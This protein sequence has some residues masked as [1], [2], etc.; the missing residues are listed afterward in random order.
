ID[1][2]ALATIEIPSGIRSIDARSVASRDAAVPE[3]HVS[4]GSI[5]VI[6]EEAP[7]AQIPAARTANAPAVAITGSSS[8]RLARHHL[9]G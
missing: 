1:D 8:R 2:L 3:L 9:R 7:T 5:E 6:V 4:I